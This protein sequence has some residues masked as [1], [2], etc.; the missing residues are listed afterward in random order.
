MLDSTLAP[1]SPP[2][3]PGQFT[4]MRLRLGAFVQDVTAGALA[5]GIAGGIAGGLGGRL[6][7]RI[8]ALMA[9]NAEQ[10]TLT[11]ADEAVG[12]I[13]L[14][15]TLALIVFGGVLVGILGGLLYV[16]AARWV[17]DAGGWRGLL[18]G[19]GLLVALGWTVIEGDNFDFATLGSVILNVIMFSAIFVLFGVLVAPLYTWIRGALG[20][21]SLSVR[22]ALSMPAYAFG[23]LLAFMIALITASAFGED[24][25]EAPMY[26]LLP[27]YLLVVTTVTAAVLA[28]RAGKF[29]RLSDLRHD[30]GAFRTALAVIAV[31]LAVGVVMDAQSLLEIFGEAY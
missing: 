10:G 18:F 14:D 12:E 23:M 31:P 13:S 1:A 8:V 22:F 6:A 26:A 5:G 3:A 24:G 4:A 30:S 7:M 20:G 9:T 25:R 17:A 15:G 21:P 19:V 16:A 29:D 27:G 28:R 2:I 11:D